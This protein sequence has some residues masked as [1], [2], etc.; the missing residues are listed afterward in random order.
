MPMRVSHPRTVR[1]DRAEL[2]AA[3]DVLA[4]CSQACTACADACLLSRSPVNR[5]EPAGQLSTPVAPWAAPTGLDWD[6]PRWR[7]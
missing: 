1:L 5:Y 7:R 4:A 6:E 3:I 2:A